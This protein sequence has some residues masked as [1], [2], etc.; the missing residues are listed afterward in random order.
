VES[1]LK[2]QAE[3]SKQLTDAI[4]ALSSII[5]QSKSAASAKAEDMVKALTKYKDDIG[6]M[7]RTTFKIPYNAN[8]HAKYNILKAGVAIGE[9]SYFLGPIITKRGPGGIGVIYNGVVKGNPAAFTSKFDVNSTAAPDNFQLNF[10]ENTKD[11]ENFIALNRKIRDDIAGHNEQLKGK[12]DT[13]QGEVKA[14]QSALKSLKANVGKDTSEA[15]TSAIEGFAQYAK[16]LGGMIIAMSAAQTAARDVPNLYT[17]ILQ[18]VLSKGMTEHSKTVKA[19]AKAVKEGE[20]PADATPAAGT[21]A[22]P[23]AA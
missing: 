5:G 4:L 14:I 12:V 1:L 9:G 3:F 2:Q 23:A 7:L 16:C 13:M 18:D 20:K 11:L 21:E 19:N 8:E 22:T 15:G 6:N 17:S 10:P